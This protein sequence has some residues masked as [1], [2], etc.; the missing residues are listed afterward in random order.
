MRTIKFRGKSVEAFK[1][2]GTLVYGYLVQSS[3]GPMILAKA[4][5]VEHE[6]WDPFGSCIVAP[7]SVAPDRG[8]EGSA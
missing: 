6:G 5:N 4:I 2:K 8:L 7:D 1:K 3:Y